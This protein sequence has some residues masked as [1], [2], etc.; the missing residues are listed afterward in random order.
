MII[1]VYV[2]S[3]TGIIKGPSP[4]NQRNAWALRRRFGSQEDT[5]YTNKQSYSNLNSK[6]EQAMKIV[7]EYANE[8][9]IEYKIYDVSK[10]GHGLRAILNGVKRTPT[11]IIGKS[12]FVETIKKEDIKRAIKRNKK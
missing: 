2:K 9:A 12:K 11:V 8:N 5:I 7:Q 6:E 3:I 1:E 10:T 4:Y